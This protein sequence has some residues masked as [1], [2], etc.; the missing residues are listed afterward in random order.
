MPSYISR[1]SFV[2]H[3]DTLLHRGVAY[4]FGIVGLLMLCWK[5][6]VFILWGGL[7]LMAVAAFWRAKKNQVLVEVSPNGIWAGQEFITDWAGFVRARITTETVHRYR[8]NTQVYTI[9]E[10]DH[11][12]EQG[13]VYRRRINISDAPLFD[14]ATLMEA[15]AHFGGSAEV[16]SVPGQVRTR[17]ID[18]DFEDI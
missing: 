10:I 15:I 12:H 16:R 14:E 1:P 13:G 4:T 18:S 8:N 7:I 11:Q 9:L 3:D 2:L 6:Q 17:W 5:P